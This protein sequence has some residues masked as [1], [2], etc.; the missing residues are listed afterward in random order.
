MPDWWYRLTVCGI[1]KEDVDK[2]ISLGTMQ[3]VNS[4]RLSGII[5]KRDTRI[6]FEEVLS[7]V[8]IN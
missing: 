1:G 3:N 2:N 8:I 7:V 5:H 4:L 6:R